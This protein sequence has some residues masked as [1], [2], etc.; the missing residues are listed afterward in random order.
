MK[1]LGELT[2]VV[3]I[4]ALTWLICCGFIYLIAMCFGF[5]FTWKIGTGVW[6]TSILLKIL[7]K[8][9]RNKGDRNE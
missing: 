9:L 7:F 3:L 1:E 6:L 4:A 5:A 2:A 8:P